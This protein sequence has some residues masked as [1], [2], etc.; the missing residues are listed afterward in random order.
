MAPIGRPPSMPPPIE[1]ERD[2]SGTGVRFLGS[3]SGAGT[4]E[5]IG[6]HQADAT[7]RPTRLIECRSFR[8]F[9][10]IEEDL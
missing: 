8:L 6:F 1:S 5:L 10:E 3:R 4:I 7:S 9:V 2:A